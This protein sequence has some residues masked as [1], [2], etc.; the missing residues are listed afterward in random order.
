M[1]MYYTMINSPVGKLYAAKTA[2]GISFL[3]FNQKEW[4]RHLKDLREDNKIELHKNDVEFF[5][6]KKVLKRYFSGEE[7][8]FSF[9]FDIFWGTTFQ[10][11][12]WNKMRKI[13]YGQTRSYK[14]LAQKAGDPRKAR[15]VGQACGS[16]PLSIL[17]PCHRVLREDGGLGGFAGGLHIKRKLL[18]LESKR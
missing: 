2:K 5:P 14:W 13:P 7:M 6:L 17:I 1:K 11:K 4:E 16:N 10:R 9:P 3:S 12:V 18:K 15:A 8:N